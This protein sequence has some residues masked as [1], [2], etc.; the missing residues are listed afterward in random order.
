MADP[1]RVR[2]M[3]RK[4]G[5]AQVDIDEVQMSHRFSTFDEYWNLQSEIAGPLAIMIKSLSL[6]ERSA[7]KDTVRESVGA[8]K[9]A[10]GLALPG[11]AVVASAT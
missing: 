8:F 4:A 6:E 3:L 10:G 7:L 1:E 5:F 9:E 11:V 2:K